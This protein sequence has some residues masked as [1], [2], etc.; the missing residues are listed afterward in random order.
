MFTPW[1]ESYDEPRQYIKKQRH[2]FASKGPYSQSFS[3]SHI[4]MWELGHVDGW[5]P[6]NWCF[7]TVEL[8]KTLESSLDIQEIKQVNTKCNQPWIFIERTDA[9]AEAPIFCLPDAK[10][11]LMRKDPY[12]GKDWVEEEKGVTEDEIVGWHHWLNGHE[13][14]HTLED[15]EGQE[16]LTCCSSWSCEKSVMT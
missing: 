11:W 3:S 1:K 13:C 4:Q 9:E 16:S 15:G 10:C 7:Q 8:E 12:G 14:V 5:A 2:N 6:K